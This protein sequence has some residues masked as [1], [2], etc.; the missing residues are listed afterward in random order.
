MCVRFFFHVY[1]SKQ[2]RRTIQN[3]HDWISNANINMNLITLSTEMNGIQLK[4]LHCDTSHGQNE[5]NERFE[6]IR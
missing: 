2:P 4:W 3:Y 5:Q 6:W 1:C